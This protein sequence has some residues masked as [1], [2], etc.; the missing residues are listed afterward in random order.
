VRQGF[1]MVPRQVAPPSSPGGGTNNEHPVGVEGGAAAPG[2]GVQVSSPSQRRPPSNSSPNATLAGAAAPGVG[3]TNDSPST[4]SDQ[5]SPDGPVTASATG[6]A[7]GRVD[8]G[9]F[10]PNGAPRNVFDNRVAT[11]TFSAGLGIPTFVHGGEH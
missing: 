3:V 4:G 5:D 6:T 1:D 7:L 11:Q 10:L 9:T 8:G 2:V